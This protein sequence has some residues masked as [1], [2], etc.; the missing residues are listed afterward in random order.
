MTQLYRQTKWLD[1]DK[2]TASK[3]N[4]EFDT[5]VNTWNAQDSGMSKFTNL[6][7]SGT[8]EFDSAA[9]FYGTALFGNTTVSGFTS[10]ATTG[11]TLGA[12]TYYYKVY[13][14]FGTQVGAPSIERSVVIGGANNAT[15]L[16]WTAVTGATGY[17]ISRGTS[18]GAQAGYYA[19]TNTSY[20]DTN[21]SFTAGGNAFSQAN[22]Q[23]ISVGG[24]IL[25]P[26]SSGGIYF[27][28]YVDGSI[29]GNISITSAGELQY[30]PGT[31]GANKGVHYF[32]DSTQVGLIQFDRNGTSSE[33]VSWNGASLANL[34]FT[35]GS[36]FTFAPNNTAT[37]ILSSSGI[38][39]GST[40]LTGLSA[41]SAS[42]DSLRYEQ[43]F[44]GDVTLAGNLIFNP[45]TKGIKGTTTND[46][47]DSG[48]VGEYSIQSRVVASALTLTTATPTNLTT[49]SMTLGAGDYDIYFSV[50][51]SGTGAVSTTI[52]T[53]LSQTSA[54][55]P[56]T[57]TLSVPS[58]TGEYW[59]QDTV[60]LGNNAESITTPSIRAKL[61]GSTTFFL[62]VRAA[63]SLGSVSAWGAMWYRR[64][65]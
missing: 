12:G 42:G 8:S 9:T 19:V 57:S 13:P 10:S 33:I 35:F 46:D 6:A 40:K 58:A 47:P 21:A 56:A 2:L 64:R 38:A 23:W 43:L 60:S 31:N 18:S 32:Q 48:D 50:A 65:R 14:T 7:V 36:N 25:M 63:F 29:A 3:L 1:I 41:G 61:S 39:M 62:V 53:A 44:G 15:S 20:T 28:D 11:G 16:G 52:E 22:S 55:F 34:I 30:Q 59:L 45:T 4:L 54:T 37:Q 5:I 27:T 24:N 17:R 51:F 26:A 49:S